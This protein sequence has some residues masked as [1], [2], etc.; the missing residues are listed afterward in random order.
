ME[1]LRE[2]SLLGW[3]LFTLRRVAREVQNHW[4]SSQLFIPQ[5]HL[6]RVRKNCPGT[7]KTGKSGEESVNSYGDRRELGQNLGIAYSSSHFQ[8]ELKSCELFQRFCTSLAPRPK[9]AQKYEL[10]HGTCIQPGPVDVRPSLWRSPLGASPKSGRLVEHWVNN[11]PESLGLGPTSI[12]KM[13][14]G[15]PI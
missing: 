3:V 7:R 5:S 2:V 11:R 12:L 13:Y 4:K 9:P 1:S 15:R 10:S 6:E 14:A 8:V